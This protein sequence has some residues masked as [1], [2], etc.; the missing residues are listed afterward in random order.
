M[1][2]TE[3]ERRARQKLVE[4]VEQ[5]NVRNHTQ[6]LKSSLTT[7]LQEE[8]KKI[9]SKQQQDELTISQEADAVKSSKLAH[10][11]V[12]RANENLKQTRK[13]YEDVAAIWNELAQLSIKRSEL[14]FRTPL[15]SK[16]INETSENWHPILKTIAQV[17]G[18][19]ANPGAVLSLLVFK[20]SD[21]VTPIPTPNITCRVD[22]DDE[23]ALSSQVM[24]EGQP[25]SLKVQEGDEVEKIKNARVAFES[26]VVSFLKDKGYEADPVALEEGKLIFRDA[27]HEL[28]D[29]AKYSELCHAP[30]HEFSDWIDDHF[31]MNM[32]VEYSSSLKP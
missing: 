18:G 17:V 5:D 24:V 6:R 23:G 27:G 12:T 2:Y 15:A 9:R 4:Q 26:V 19:I 20:L 16:I 7:L 32:N 29:K 28:L 8:G 22:M 14:E 10:E 11:I 13:G 3:E 31:G 1:P 30:E 25:I 21:L